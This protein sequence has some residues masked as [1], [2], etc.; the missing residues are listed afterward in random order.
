[1]SSEIL[2]SYEVFDLVHTGLAYAFILGAL[3][4]V[5]FVIYGGIS[6]IISGG[7]ED[8]VKKAVTTIKHA[9][10]GIVIIILSITII[11]FLGRMFNVNLLFIKF[12]LIIEQ[13]QNI[14]QNLSNSSTTPSLPTTP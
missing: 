6:F 2:Y 8:K 13:T 1:M 12:E 10:V 9:L 4:S 11:A 7:Q 14:I 3:L 5:F